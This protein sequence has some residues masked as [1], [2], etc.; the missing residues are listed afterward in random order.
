MREGLVLLVE[1]EDSLADL[2]AALLGR[3][4]IRVIRASD[5]A[6]AVQLFQQHR[7][8]IALALVDCQLPDCGGAEVCNDLRAASPG[9]P[10]LLTSGRDQRVL[11]AH[12]AVSGPCQFLP[13][14]FM[15][16]DVTRRVSS[17]LAGPG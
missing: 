17:L 11:E 3:M 1:D 5:G 2:I 6:Q 9:L 12:F 16:G 10:L 7:A 4:R 13:K 8:E 15:P 14:P